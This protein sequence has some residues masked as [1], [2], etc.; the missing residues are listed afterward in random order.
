MR[1]VLTMTGMATAP[2]SRHGCL[3]MVAQATIAVV[4]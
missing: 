3:E 1:V 2:L 4:G